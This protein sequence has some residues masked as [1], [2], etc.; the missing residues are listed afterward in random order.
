MN[1]EVIDFAQIDSA[2]QAS[3]IE[4]GMWRLKI[5]APS[6]TVET[7]DK[8]TPFLKVKFLH[9][10][11]GSL[12]E[13]FYLT[14]KVMPR[15]QYLHE[16]WFSKKLDKKFT[17]MLEVGQ[18]FAKALT[19]KIVTRPMITGGKITV[20]GDFYSGLPY[21][22]FIVADENQFEEGPFEKDSVRYKNVVQIEKT[23]PAVAN[24]NNAILPGA[25]A[26]AEDVSSPWD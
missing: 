16:A 14:P 20:K 3:F 25:D 4:P 22:G 1:N 8:K 10:N 13:K 19:S 12:T 9:E 21:T 7:P 6:V 15:F 23:N 18:Y 2:T 24:T 26:S 5:D 17:S 11:G